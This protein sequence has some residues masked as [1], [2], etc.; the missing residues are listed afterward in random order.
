MRWA[1]EGQSCLCLLVFCSFSLD[2]ETPKYSEIFLAPDGL[3]II[4]SNYGSYSWNHDT[5]QF[6]PFHFTDEAHLHTDRHVYSPDGRLFACR[7]DNNGHIRVWDTRT[8]QL[9]G[10]PIIIPNK[11]SEIALSPAMNDQS[12]G[13][14]LT[15]TH[16]WDTN[17]TSLFDVYTGCLYAEFWSQGQDIVFIRD[18]TK[19]IISVRPFVIQ[20]I[21]D[22]TVK[23]R[24]WYKLNLGDMEDGW[25]TGQEN[26]SLFWVPVK[27]REN[28]C[29]LPQFETIWGQSKK[30]N[31]SRFRYSNGWTECI[32]KEWLKELEE[33]E[34][35]MGS[36]L[37]WEHK[38]QDSR[39][40]KTDPYLLSK[41]V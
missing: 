23:H 13:N 32:D 10:N 3:T 8:G 39:E 38:M 22:L 34:K 6:D 25:M 24:D 7:S 33:K 18:G 16:C 30:L 36:L 15:A 19:L 28:L 26:E 41:C 40:D 9:C 35:K 4:I 5:V 12:L 37:G 21:V 2:I 11:A 31:L 14:R 1:V 27:H 20:D 29:P 17:T